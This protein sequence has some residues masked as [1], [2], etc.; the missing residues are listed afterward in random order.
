MG[1]GLRRASMIIEGVR[2][3]GVAGIVIEWVRVGET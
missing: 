2:V 3:G 1:G